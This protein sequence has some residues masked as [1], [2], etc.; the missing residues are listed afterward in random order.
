[1]DRKLT[2]SFLD[3]RSVE[4]HFSRNER[5]LRQYVIEHPAEQVQLLQAD[6]GYESSK[7]ANGWLRLLWPDNRQNGWSTVHY[8]K[9]EKLTP[10]DSKDKF[11]FS[12]CED[13]RIKSRNCFG[14]WLGSRRGPMS[15]VKVRSVATFLEDGGRE[16]QFKPRELEEKV[17]R[18]SGLLKVRWT[19]ER[20]AP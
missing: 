2:V 1:M 18:S 12:F 15:A 17:F 20:I 16:L 13:V 19:L 7:D 8:R 6:N 14:L 4:Y 3:D 9:L 5:P 11:I 10:A